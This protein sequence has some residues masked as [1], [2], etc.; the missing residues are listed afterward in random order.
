[1]RKFSLPKSTHKAQDSSR[2][3]LAQNLPYSYQVNVTTEIINCSI[4]ISW[5]TCPPLLSRVRSNPSIHMT[6]QWGAVSV[7]KLGE[8][9]LLE[10]SRDKHQMGKNH[11][12][13]SLT[14]ARMRTHT[15]THTQREKHTP[16]GVR[17][18]LFHM[19]LSP[20]INLLCVF[21]LFLHRYPPYYTTHSCT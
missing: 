6:Q 10:Q 17:K 20:I 1:M 14:H 19:C 13:I 21:I 4:Q 11:V 7:T 15:H 8:E 16:I 9:L 18:C 5:L 2:I 12:F 3:D